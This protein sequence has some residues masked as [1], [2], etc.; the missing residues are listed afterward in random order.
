MTTATADRVMKARH[1]SVCTVCQRLI[2][3][4][5]LI[6]KTGVWQH[7]QHVLDRQKEPA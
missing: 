3:P 1:E 7:I 4:G 2:R 5:D 6:A